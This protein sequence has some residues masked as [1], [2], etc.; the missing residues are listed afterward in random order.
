MRTTLVVLSFALL[1]T[2][3][4]SNSESKAQ[5]QSKEA[6][7]LCAPAPVRYEQW[8]EQAKSIA[9]QVKGIDQVVAVQIDKELDVAVKVT[10]FNRFRLESIQKEVAKRLKD[11]FPDSDIHV[12]ADKKL[13]RELQKF[14]ENPWPT[15]VKEACKQKKKFKQFEKKMKG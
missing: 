8:E 14:G 3:C 4:G 13:I 10:N 11:A 5:V 9:G 6:E 12:T 15:D 1:M 2:G 7:P